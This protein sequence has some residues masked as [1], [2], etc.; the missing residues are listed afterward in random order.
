MSLNQAEVIVSEFKK[1]MDRALSDMKVTGTGAILVVDPKE[2]DQLRAENQA[3]RELVR[4]A[5]VIMEDVKRHKGD[6]VDEWLKK[7][8]KA[9]V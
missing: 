4:E 3:L 1:L 5:Q 2:Y 8:E 7:A 9:E 6:Q